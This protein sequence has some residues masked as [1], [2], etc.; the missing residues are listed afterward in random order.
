MTLTSNSKNA[1]NRPTS[2]KTTA[3][4]VLAS[5][6]IADLGSPVRSASPSVATG[7]YAPFYGLKLYY[8]VHGTGKP[9]MLLRGGLGAL[10]M[11]GDVLPL[12]A[13]DRQV[14]AVDL[15]AHGRTGDTNRP[16]A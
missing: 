5:T 1:L 8:E 13:K 4:A 6:S 7:N 9:L 2:K 10:E 3:M 15:Q 16:L 14:I 11:F 12:L